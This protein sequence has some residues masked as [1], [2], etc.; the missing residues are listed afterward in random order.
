MIYGHIGIYIGG[1]IV[2]DN[3]GY[4]RSISA[5]EW[6]SY[7]STSVPVRWGWLGGIALD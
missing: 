2:M 6:I 5:D 1:G 3:I 4:I 7:Y